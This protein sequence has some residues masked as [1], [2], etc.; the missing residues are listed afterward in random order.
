MKTIVSSLFALGLLAASAQAILITDC[1]TLIGNTDKDPFK[2]GGSGKYAKWALGVIQGQN[3]PAPG[4]P[5]H[6]VD[7]SDGTNTMVMLTGSET[8]MMLHWGN[9]GIG[10]MAYQLYDIR[11]CAPG[12]YELPSPRPKGGGLSWIGRF[13]GGTGGGNNSVPDGGTTVAL[14]GLALCGL[15]PLKKLLGK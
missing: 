11:N 7:I 3:L 12:K 15:F 9:G 4:A 1:A 6:K 5:F 14:M 13:G 8:Y 10:D 2:G